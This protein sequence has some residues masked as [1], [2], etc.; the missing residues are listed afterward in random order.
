MSFSGRGPL[1]AM[2]LL[3]CSAP[4]SAPPQAVGKAGVGTQC[5]TGTAP[6]DPDHG[7]HRPQGGAPV[8]VRHESRMGSSFVLVGAA[9]YVDR[10]LVFD[11]NDA[12]LLA[13]RQIR[14]LKTSLAPGE[15]TAGVYLRYR[16][17]GTGVFS[18]LSGYQFEVRGSHVFRVD[19]A[20]PLALTVVT[21][22]QGGATTP[23]EE[24][25]AVS[26]QV[27]SP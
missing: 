13:Q 17:H 7:C 26:F 10:E 4:S 8:V 6:Y 15:H 20:A 9:L 24:R 2:A 22:E 18:Y 14:L 11:S 3:G 27:G 5:F 23:L 19:A 16:G 25:P 1:F 21:A 12:A